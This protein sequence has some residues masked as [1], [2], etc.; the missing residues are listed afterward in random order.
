VN[1]HFCDLEEESKDGFLIVTVV[2]LIGS[3]QVC[4]VS[5]PYLVLKHLHPD[6][7]PLNLTF[8]PPSLL[9]I[10]P[11][12]TLPSLRHEPI[13]WHPFKIHRSWPVPR[14]TLPGNDGRHNS[15]PGDAEVQPLREAWREVGDLAAPVVCAGPDRVDSSNASRGDDQGQDHTDDSD[16]IHRPALSPAFMVRIRARHRV[17]QLV[18]ESPQAA[19]DWVGKIPEVVACVYARVRVDDF[20]PLKMLGR[21]A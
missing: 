13:Q 6:F 1:T 16:C 14:S 2:I 11:G 19:Q 18:A 10:G 15:V 20:E 21:G 4:P 8:I 7:I 9:P 12:L 17:L 3:R 5:P